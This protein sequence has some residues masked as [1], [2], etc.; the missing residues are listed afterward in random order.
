[1]KDKQMLI[2]TAIAK[3]SE[4][5][6]GRAYFIGGYVRDK[7]MNMYHNY[8]RHKNKNKD[9]D[10]EIYGIPE[11]ELKNVLESIDGVSV[12]LVGESFKVFKVKGYKIDVSLPRIEYKVKGKSYN[13]HKDFEVESSHLMSFYEACKRRDL[14]INAV[15][16][17]IITGKIIDP[18]LGVSHIRNKVMIQ[19]SSKFSED[20]VRVLRVMQFISRFDEFTIDDVLMEEC[21]SISWEGL[22]N[23]R[24]FDELKKLILLGVKPSKGLNFLVDCGWIQLF[25]EL[26]AMIGCLQDVRYHPEGDVWTHICHCMDKFAELIRDESISKETIL[27]TGLGVLLHDIGKPNTTEV[28]QDGSITSKGHD[29]E[30]VILGK[31]FLDRLT[32]EHKIFDEVLPLIG[33]HMQPGF[34]YDRTNNKSPSTKA[35]K[36]LIRR[37]NVPNLCDVV[38]ADMMGRPPSI[39]DVGFLLELKDKYHELKDSTPINQHDSIIQGRHLIS[40]GFKPS[41]IFSEIIAKCTEAELNGEIVDVESGRKFIKENYDIK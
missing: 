10:I 3:A 7:L 31:Q 15:L 25:P 21:R 5:A 23:E 30:G 22:S 35:I 32:T 16:E 18:Y 40:M 2:A 24:V 1:M 26:A 29:V 19:T 41:P 11:D 8:P 6:K 33:C 20:P 36:R 14:T 34:L 27:Y 37:V 9:I 13:S 28:H 38:F 4:L 17:D 39:P 12:D